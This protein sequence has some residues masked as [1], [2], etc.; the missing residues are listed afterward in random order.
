[1]HQVGLVKWELWREWGQEASAQAPQ[2]LSAQAEQRC[3][4][5]KAGPP[6]QL[7]RPQ[8]TVEI[9]LC[10]GLLTP[11][12]PQLPLDQAHLVTANALFDL[13]SP[14][15]FATFIAQLGGKPLWATLNY[16]A[17]AFE[18]T[19]D[20]DDHWVIDRYQAHM[21]RPGAGLTG[22]MGPSCSDTMATL[23][24]EAGYRVLRDDSVWQ[25]GPD[26]AT[27]ISFVL[28]FMAQ[29]VPE[30]C[31]PND[32]PRFTAWLDRRRNALAHKRLG[33]RVE[34]GDLLAL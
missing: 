28:G 1:C 7:D 19:P 6:I 26:D 27:L 17:M 33:L 23:L 14:Q 24:T 34:H 9:A 20:P 16:T 15:A 12:P 13:L 18:G 22:A 5:Y 2:A 11:L 30:M 32:H 25:L 29:A 8:G 4:T 10:R 21:Q 31:T 3:W